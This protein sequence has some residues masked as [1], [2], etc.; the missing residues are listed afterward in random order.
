MDYTQRY[1]YDSF[2]VYGSG[3]QFLAEDISGKQVAFITCETAPVDVRFDAPD[4]VTDGH[5]LSVGDTLTLFGY[6]NIRRF[7]FN[8][9]GGTLKVSFGPDVSL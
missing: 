5:V 6:N 1:Q 8:L 7:R 3:S 2:K 4:T 9:G